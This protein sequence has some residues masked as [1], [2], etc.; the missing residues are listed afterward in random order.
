MSEAVAVFDIGATNMK[1]ALVDG[2]GQV[3]VSVR[4]ENRAR[5]G[6]P[7]L[8][9]DT[10]AIWNWICETLASLSGAAE[11][12]AI[13]PCTH[14]SAMALV[15][16][17]AKGDPLAFPI[18]YYEA[19]PPKKIRRGYRD[20]APPFDEVLAPTNPGGLT[21][22]RQLFWQRQIDR[23]AFDR[24]TTI[25]PYAQYW[26]WRLTGVPRSEVTSLGAQT[27]I[28]APTERDYSSLA[29]ELGIRSKFAPMARA[30]EPVGT[31]LPSVAAKT[32]LPKDTPVLA[33]IHDSNAN[34]FRYLAAGMRDFTLL[35]T[36]T[37]II[38]FNPAFDPAGL[39]ADYDTNTNTNVFG[40]PVCCSR[41]MGGRE[42]TILEGSIKG[43]TSAPDIARLI[44]WDTMALPSFTDS[45][46]P[47]PG[48]GGKG[49]VVGETPVSPSD[50]T[51]LASLYCALMT[52]LS[53][54]HI[55]SANEIVIDG[56]FA[57]NQIF[58][59]LL[60]GL[61]PDQTVRVSAERDGTVLGASLLWNWEQ[62]RE[63]AALELHLVKPL[64][65]DG[66][67]DYAARWREE[68]SKAMAQG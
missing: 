59:R 13:V 51:A 25:M 19:D 29:D 41:F 20:V 44:G 46:G 10:E 57:E 55:G 64:L 54:G 34:Y 24:V 61:R 6:P 2:R 33:G 31:L 7:Y 22:G 40:D 38:N 50:R 47:C 45:G 39:V 65:L 12:R 36:G 11:I 1:A 27:H 37:W 15:D 9:A 5:S 28:W 68:V 32:G 4:S 56:A 26:A 35:S 52:D 58:C 63:P 66:L 48:T 49:K 21:V 53:I 62:R 42:F 23:K 16:D 8:H 14:G 30:W 18:M 43:T 67:Q 60:A 3:L 17:N